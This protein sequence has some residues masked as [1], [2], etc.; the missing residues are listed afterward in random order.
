LY[1]SSFSEWVAAQ[2]TLYE[3]NEQLEYAMREAD[4][5]NY[6]KARTMVKKNKEY[7]QS[8][9]PL[10]QKSVELQ[11]AESVN[12]SYDNSL[13]NIESMSSTEVKQ[14]QKASKASNYGVRNKK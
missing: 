7:M 6:E 11:K 2:I 9:A 8:K 13:L 14:I 3:S 10:V 4:K 1:N 12:D 5:G